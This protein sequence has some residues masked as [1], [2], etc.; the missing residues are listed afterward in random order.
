MQWNQ[1]I[2]PSCCP[3]SPSYQKQPSAF[4]PTKVP[5]CFSK[6]LH[7][8]FLRVFSAVGCR[9]Q[10]L[11]EWPTRSCHAGNQ[12]G[13]LLEI[14][15]FIALPTGTVLLLPAEGLAQGTYSAISGKNKTH[16]PHE[17]H[18][19]ATSI[20][21]KFCKTQSISK[22]HLHLHS[23]FTFWPMILE[24]NTSGKSLGSQSRVSVFA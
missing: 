4:S 20:Q 22:E 8:Y 14:L 13:Y 1:N 21:P 12:E 17:P 7:V 24:S 15:D 16:V 11:E 6:G 10:I 23:V 3:P 9:S 2:P 18:G 5:D 19:K